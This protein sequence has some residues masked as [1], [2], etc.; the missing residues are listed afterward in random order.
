M[1]YHTFFIAGLCEPKQRPC[2]DLPPYVSKLIDRDDFAFSIYACSDS[3]HGARK[4][5]LDL[6]LY[7]GFW[8]KDVMACNQYDGKAQTHIGRLTNTKRSD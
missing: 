3:N 1:K 6:L 4:A 7:N 5:A 2:D 8:V